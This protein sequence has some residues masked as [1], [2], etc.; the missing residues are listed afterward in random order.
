VHINVSLIIAAEEIY[1]TAY[2]KLGKAAIFLSTYLTL[3]SRSDTLSLSPVC[4]RELE[5]GKRAWQNSSSG[6]AQLS[7]P[8]K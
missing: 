1:K 7:C 4:G 5:R 3:S 6:A 2:R 8:L